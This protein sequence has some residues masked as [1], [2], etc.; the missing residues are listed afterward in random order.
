[1]LERRLR[2][3]ELYDGASLAVGSSVGAGKEWRNEGSGDNGSINDG[4]YNIELEEGRDGSSCG[5]V[6]K[7]NNNLGINIL[8]ENVVNKNIEKITPSTRKKRTKK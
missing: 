7:E 6:G 1:V 8:N 3:R 2:F 4:G 5:E